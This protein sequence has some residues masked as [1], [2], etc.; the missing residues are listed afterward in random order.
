M[1]PRPFPNRR[2]GEDCPA[3]TFDLQRWQAQPKPPAVDRMHL[4]GARPK[5][6]ISPIPSR[7]NSIRLLTLYTSILLSPASTLLFALSSL[8]QSFI[9]LATVDS[10]D[11]NR[12]C[13]DVIH[14]HAYPQPVCPPRAQRSERRELA[15][16]A[17]TRPR[18]RACRYSWLQGFFSHEH[19]QRQKSG[20]WRI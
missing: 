14:H 6:P 16:S 3:E 11:S 4:P 17:T 13:L 15:S 9:P 20:Q 12:R 1:L 2:A 7:P 8:T 18:L 19:P 5:M 10:T